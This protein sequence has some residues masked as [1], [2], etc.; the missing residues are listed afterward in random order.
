MKKEIYSNLKDYRETGKTK[1]KLGRLVPTADI[2]RV[3]SMGDSTKWSYKL[4]T[5]T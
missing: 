3:F 4:Y 2:K 5:I 1:Y